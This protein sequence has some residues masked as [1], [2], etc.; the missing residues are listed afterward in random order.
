MKS[1]FKGIKKLITLIL[2]IIIFVAGYF[3]KGGYD[4]YKEAMTQMSLEKRV[5]NLQSDEGY[6]KLDEISKDYLDAVVSVEDKRFYEHN[7]LD[8]YA[9]GGATVYTFQNKKVA[10]GASTIS[11]Q[12]AKNLCLDQ[13][14]TITRKIAEVFATLDIEKNY[15]KNE[16]LEMYVNIAYF[17]D[18][19][20]GIGYA[21]EG[22]FEKSPSELDLNE[23]TLLAGLPNAPSVYQLSNN[24]DGTYLRQIV[25]IKS[26]I[27]NG[28]L[29]KTAGEEL[30]N[31]IK[32][33]RGI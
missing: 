14:K 33:D 16:I 6:V 2:V 12:L 19:Y 21:T 7:G 32:E 29:D 11:Q 24:N 27:K 9:I 17:G 15:S 18:G 26:M 13:R 10:F 22:Y 5:E 3:I 30:I 23:A 25:V 1:F 8:I 28:Y 31:N 20:Y 4:Y